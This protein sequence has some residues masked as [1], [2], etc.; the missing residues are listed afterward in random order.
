MKSILKSV[1]IVFVFIFSIQTAHAQDSDKTVTLTVSGTGKTIE[2]AKTN[3]LRSAIEQAFGAFISSKTEILNDNLIKDEIV[4]V[5]NGN[6]QKYD[7]VSQVELPKIGYAITLSATVSISK[8]TS[9]AESKG[10]VVEFKGG[11]F[12]INIKLKELNEKAE[13]K[14]IRNLSTTL[15]DMLQESYDYNLTVSEPKFDSNN[16]NYKINFRISA[17]ENK[18]YEIFINY[19]ISTVN[20]IALTEAE[21]SEF[22]NTG[23]QTYPFV[24]D[25]RLYPLRSIYSMVYL[26][27]FFIGA[28]LITTNSFG[29]Y[30]DSGEIVK[31]RSRAESIINAKIY[32]RYDKD[33]IILFE[34]VT[35]DKKDYYDSAKFLS[36]NWK[37]FQDDKDLFE[38]SKL[39]LNSKFKPAEICFNKKFSLNEIEKISSFSI[40]KISFFDLIKNRNSYVMK[41][42]RNDY[43]DEIIRNEN[44]EIIINP[45]VD[46]SYGPYESC[47]Y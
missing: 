5:A 34:D 45:D 11:L 28:S 19:F 39:I 10:V 30:T 4:S 18:N 26:H 35:T 24:I 40:K 46:D 33:L 1:I 6:V 13:Y 31:I 23:K 3:A 16:K 44:G 47:K 17:V 29:I 22:Q 9:F 43:G 38:T 21:A 27:N 37:L 14:A 15:L 32:N 7:V 25:G 42:D 36:S 2:E 12:A 20:K 8:L 41:Y